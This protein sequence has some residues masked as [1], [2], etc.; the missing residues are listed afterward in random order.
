MTAEIGILNKQGV[1]IAADSA[2][3]VGGQKVY[4][5]SN[6]MF[7][8]GQKHFVGLMTFGNAEFMSV[9]WQIIFRR[10]GKNIGDERLTHMK[11]YADKLVD[12]VRKDV[13][14]HDSVSMNL[15]VQGY[16]FE[17]CKFIYDDLKKQIA[18]GC[19]ETEVIELI[20]KIIVDA[21]N[22]VKSQKQLT[23]NYPYTEFCE[24][25]HSVILN[26]F[27]SFKIDEPI[28]KIFSE[29][30]LTSSIFEPLQNLIYYFIT[31][32]KDVLS[33]SGIVVAGYGEEDI[34][35]QLYAFNFY[36]NVDSHLVFKPNSDVKIGQTAV[37]PYATAAIMPF[38][39]QD[40]AATI[41]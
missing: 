3:T 31:Q 41:W 24:S 6:K 39:Q 5:T 25:Y 33:Y 13:E 35:P 38:A 12:F 8:L 27:S 1:V 14:L 17:M 32:G 4:N 19:S 15:Y 30:V 18:P 10:F 28:G 9:P 40:V 29:N 22:T 36:G 16:S 7:T 21:L 23:I 37:P 11:D 2:V 26:A 34:F 20:K